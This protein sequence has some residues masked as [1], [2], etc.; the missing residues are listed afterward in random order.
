MLTLA[1]GVEGLL[2]LDLEIKHHTVI[3][4]TATRVS[5]FVQESV[6]SDKQVSHFLLTAKIS[7]TNIYQFCKQSGT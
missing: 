7:Q 3:L 1:R 4:L 2:S 6:K 5:G